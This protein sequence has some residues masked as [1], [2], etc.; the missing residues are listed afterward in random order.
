M[1]KYVLGFAH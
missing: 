1:Y